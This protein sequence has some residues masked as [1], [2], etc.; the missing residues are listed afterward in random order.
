MNINIGFKN[1]ST[2]SSVLSILTTKNIFHHQ[3]L[4]YS[5]ID[6]FQ[7]EQK[8][9]AR[10][11]E[12]EEMKKI[13][14]EKQERAENILEEDREIYEKREN[15][16]KEEVERMREE[17]AL[18]IY[19][20]KLKLTEEQRKLRSLINTRNQR[21]RR[22]EARAARDESYKRK[23]EQGLELNRQ[24]GMKTRLQ[25]PKAHSLNLTEEQKKTRDKAK[26]N[27]NKRHRGALARQLRMIEKSIE[28]Q[29]SPQKKDKKTDG[30]HETNQSNLT[31]DGQLGSLVPALAN[32]SR[33]PPPSENEE[34]KSTGFLTSIP[35]QLLELWRR[36]KKSDP[37]LSRSISISY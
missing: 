32:T 37:S 36:G 8:R 19:G 26:R 23:Y 3:N 28:D 18:G 13:R 2:R 31:E 27:F 21:Q 6:S 22:R 10:E 9:I 14:K 29:I 16:I 25:I 15:R 34:K 12:R 11:E 30:G 17:R 33:P 1:C 7:K 4:V 5:S 24:R 35:R 20:S